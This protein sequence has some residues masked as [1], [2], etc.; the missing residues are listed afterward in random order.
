MLPEKDISIKAISEAE[1]GSKKPRALK[2]KV[3][4]PIPHSSITP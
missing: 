4:S 1:G 3:I 2:E